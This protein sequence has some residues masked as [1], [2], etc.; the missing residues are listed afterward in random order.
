MADASSPKWS[1][2]GEYFE[3]CNCAVACPCIFSAEPPFT[4]TPTEGAC[5]VAFAFHIDAGSFG[6][7]RLDGLNAG[8]IAR[9][10]GPM[11]DGNWQVALYIDERA[12]QQQHDAIQAIF[13]GAAGG[14]MGAFAPLIGEVLGIKSAPISYSVSGKRRSVEIPGFMSMAVG[15]VPSA[16]GEDV[17]MVARNAH[18]FAPEGVVMAVGQPG[19]TWSDYGM[20]WD[21]SG[22]NGHYAPIHWSNG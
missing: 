12:D 13:A 10:P 4:S 3:N 14:T 6:D 20:R 9:P 19:S 8:L 18:P 22:R 2:D 1:I 7:T 16:M 17:E 5:E 21:N 15:P 11:I